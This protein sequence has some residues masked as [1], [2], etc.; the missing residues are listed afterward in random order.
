MKLKLIQTCTHNDNLISVIE[1][2]K[3]IMLE[4]YGNYYIGINSRLE[5][6]SYFN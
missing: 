5:L 6:I 1:E 4:K 2:Q 3:Q